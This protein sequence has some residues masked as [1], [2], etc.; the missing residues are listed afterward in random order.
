M[1]AGRPSQEKVFPA[2]PEATLSQQQAEDI[3]KAAASRI[4]TQKVRQ[5]CTS[6]IPRSE[7]MKG[8][9]IGVAREVLPSNNSAQQLGI[10]AMQVD[11]LRT[12]REGLKTRGQEFDSALRGASKLESSFGE[13]HTAAVTADNGVAASLEN[14]IVP[15]SQPSGSNAGSCEDVYSSVRLFRIIRSKSS[16]NH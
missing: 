13:I 11:Q 12:V 2:A 14:P 3:V 16:K 10:I 1:R 8:E 9:T 15:W 7:Q 6:E 5:V 4:A